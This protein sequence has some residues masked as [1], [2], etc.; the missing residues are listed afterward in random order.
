M[1]PRTLHGSSSQQGPWQTICLLAREV[2]LQGGRPSCH[3]VPFLR[4]A[5]PVF[6]QHA[7]H[8]RVLFRVFSQCIAPEKVWHH[9]P[10]FLLE[11]TLSHCCQNDVLSCHALAFCCRTRKLLGSLHSANAMSASPSSTVNPPSPLPVCDVDVTVRVAPNT[12]AI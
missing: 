4:L 1:L 3:P 8:A 9:E 6:H 11:D 12:G 10:G 2:P 5:R 7:L